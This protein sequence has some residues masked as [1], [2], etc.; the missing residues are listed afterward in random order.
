MGGSNKRHPFDV[1]R[2]AAAASRG[3]G[4]LWTNQPNHL[5]WRFF[6]PYCESMSMMES[7]HVD[8]R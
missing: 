8:H 1:L 6:G 3:E 7:D 5:T 4:E 2:S